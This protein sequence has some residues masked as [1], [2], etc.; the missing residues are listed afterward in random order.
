LI[1]YL[2]NIQS[3]IL[4]PYVQYILFN[5]CSQK[6]FTNTVTSFPNTNICLGI[7][8]DKQLYQDTNGSKC[9]REK[10]GINSYISSLYTTPYNFIGN[11]LQD[12]ICIDFTPLGFC[13]FFKCTSETFISYDKLLNDIFTSKSI[14]R[15]EK[16]FD[17]KDFM[18]R[19]KM[20]EDILL[21]EM[22]PFE[23]ILLTEVLDLIKSSGGDINVTT[24]A[25]K[26]KVSSKTI[27]RNFMNHLGISPNQ[28]IRIQRFR[29]ALSL[30][31]YSGRTFTS[32]AYECGFTDPSHLAKDIWH[33]TASTPGHLQSS[34]QNIDNTVV[35]R[36]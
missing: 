3:S 22:K 2:Y 6:N 1:F 35:F 32:I 20:I 11:G 8:R 15:F 29:K 21:H 19:G 17:E 24:L 14:G 36:F 16:V 23:N 10:P 5:H 13:K 28:Y 25:V 34:I 27:Y 31:H 7:I 12:E 4:K 33:F 30:I 18:I 9:L 26:S